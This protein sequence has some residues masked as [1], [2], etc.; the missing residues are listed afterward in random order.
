M[1]RD[2]KIQKI[3]EHF[4]FLQDIVNATEF[5]AEVRISY[6]KKFIGFGA[7]SYRVWVESILSDSHEVGV[8]VV[9]YL[10]GGDLRDISLYRRK[11]IETMD[12]G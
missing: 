1:T 3:N 7:I 5:T 11:C 6:Y 8:Y 4:D 10:C 12:L 2:E 9:M